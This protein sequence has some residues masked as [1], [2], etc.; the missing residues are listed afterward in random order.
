[1]NDRGMTLVEI[2]VVMILISI[3]SAIVLTRIMDIPAVSTTATV[4]IVKA[5]LRYA[6]SM[7]M[8]QNNYLWGLKC[9]G[10]DYWLFRTERR[11]DY[12]TVSGDQDTPIYLPGEDN[13]KLPASGMSA[14][15]AVYFDAYG[16]PRQYDSGKTV[17]LTSSLNITVGGETIQISPETGFIE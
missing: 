11:D 3:V 5:H 17:L 16:R 13:Q 7:A 14:F 10:N 6:Q 15:D 8:K 2:I 9:D 4:E 1:M 12:T